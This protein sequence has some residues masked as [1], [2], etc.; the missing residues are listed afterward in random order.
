ME[1]HLYSLLAGARQ[2]EG[3]VVIIDVYRAFTTAAMAFSRG[4]EKIILVA[5]VEEA[6]DLRQRGVGHL[7]MG[8]V[9]GKRPPGFDLGNSPFEVSRADLQDKILIQSTRAGTVG[10]TAAQ[11][12]EALFAGALVSARA[13]AAALCEAS[14]DCVSLVAMGSQGKVRTDEDEQCALYLRNLLEGRN[15]DPE[16]VRQLVLAGGD[17]QKFDDPHQPQ[18]Q[19]EDRDLA[20]Q[21]NSVDFAIKVERDDGQL[22]ARPHQ[23]TE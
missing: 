19:P 9:D 16:A 17:S 13:T 22:V 1:I 10:A 15:P 18:Y 7:C 2:A 8:E 6:L 14:P 21:I 11:K 20:L 23:R 3:T 4:A 5:E 12:A